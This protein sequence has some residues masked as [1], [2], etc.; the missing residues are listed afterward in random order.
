VTRRKKA[1]D[2]PPD[3]EIGARAKAKRLRFRSKPETS[4]EF[5]G[6]TRV[7]SDDRIE[8]VELET[9]ERSER[10]NLPD[11]VEPGVTYRDVEVGWAAQARAR[12]SADE[13]DEDEDE[14]G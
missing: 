9:E 12:M 2:R 6:G 1:S 4:V 5:H 11:E 10:R 14:R 7:R 3:I 13:Q 8:N